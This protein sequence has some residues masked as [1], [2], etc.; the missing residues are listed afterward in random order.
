MRSPTLAVQGSPPSPSPL[1]QRKEGNGRAARRARSKKKRLLAEAAASTSNTASAHQVASD[2]ATAQSATVA[3]GDCLQSSLRNDLPTSIDRGDT[4]GTPIDGRKAHMRNIQ[5][6]EVTEDQTGDLNLGVAR[7]PT[8]RAPNTNADTD[9]SDSSDDDAAELAGGPELEELEAMSAWDTPYTAEPEPGSGAV[10][11]DDRRD[12][13]QATS[14]AEAGDDDGR[15]L[16]TVFTPTVIATKHNG[17]RNADPAHAGTPSQGKSALTPEGGSTTGADAHGSGDLHTVTVRLDFGSQFEALGER[18][19]PSASRVRVRLDASSTTHEVR[20]QVAADGKVTQR[21]PRIPNAQLLKATLTVNGKAWPDRT[22]IRAMMPD[23]PTVDQKGPAGAREGTPAEP[24]SR[25]S[26]LMQHQHAAHPAQDWPTCPVADQHREIA[27]GD[28]PFAPPTQRAAKAAASKAAWCMEEPADTAQWL[29]FA[30]ENATIKSHS[31]SLPEVPNGTW[32]TKPGEPTSIYAPMRWAEH[33]WDAQRGAWPRSYAE[34]AKPAMHTTAKGGTTRHLEACHAIFEDTGGPWITQWMRRQPQAAF[35]DKA[36]DRFVV[37][38]PQT[39]W[40]ESDKAARMLQKD[41]EGHLRVCQDS[42]SVDGSYRPRSAMLIIP[43]EC[44][45]GRGLITWDKRPFLI[46]RAAGLPTHDILIRPLETKRA[47]Q[48]NWNEARFR[49]R[50]AAA[51][52]RDEFAMDMATSTGVW[53]HTKARNDTMI[54]PCYRSATENAEAARELMAAEERQGFITAGFDGLPL[55]PM[56]VQPYSAQVDE[57]KPEK[58][59]RFCGDCTAFRGLEKDDGSE[60]VANSTNAGIQWRDTEYLSMMELTSA[61]VIARD[62][63]I[64]QS[65]PHPVWVFGADYKGYYR[66]IRMAYAE[67]NQQGLCL[68]STGIRIDLSA[69]FGNAAMPTQCCRISDILTQLHH[70]EVVRMFEL[71]LEAE[72]ESG[73]SYWSTI[74]TWARARFQLLCTAHAGTTD[75]PGAAANPDWRER[76]SRPEVI[77]SFFDDVMG[78]AFR[79]EISTHVADPKDPE[80]RDRHSEDGMHGLVVRAILH[81]SDDVGVTLA[82]HKLTCGTDDGR[83]GVLDMDKWLQDKA[84][85]VPP[86]ERRI[87]W[88]LGKGSMVML[89]KEIRLPKPARLADTDARIAG[90]VKD[91]NSLKAEMQVKANRPAV[92]IAPLRS[93]VQRGFYSVTTAPYAR[94]CLNVP[95]RSL[96]LCEAVFPQ[97]E[98]EHR[99][100][101]SSLKRRRKGRRPWFSWCFFDKKCQDHMQAFIDAIVAGAG[102]ALVPME[103]TPGVHGRAVV[104]IMEDASGKKCA[105]WSTAAQPRLG[106]A[107]AGGGGAFYYRVGNPQMKWSFSEHTLLEEENHS[108]TQEANNANANALRAIEWAGTTDLDIIEC[109]DNESWTMVARSGKCDAEAVS[110]PA[111]KRMDIWAG[112]P[113]V[114]IFTLFNRRTAGTC[115]DGFSNGEI[116]YEPDQT[117][118]CCRQEADS[119]RWTGIEWAIEEVSARTGTPKMDLVRDRL[120]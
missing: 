74:D 119:D 49:A 112:N 63:G 55:E 89:G 27:G 118:S 25:I 82:G 56:R 65:G 57:R 43:Q 17:T 71:K 8:H 1:E 13:V 72:Q 108:T 32:S 37:W 103:T 21:R 6:T 99:A 28:Y 2:T 88:F 94:P 53:T 52:V 36:G 11:T 38:S 73:G 24:W 46:A 33:E 77:Q 54:H 12:H 96:K 34:Q 92:P 85:G 91:W 105:D 98:K 5:P 80:Q 93:L 9:S 7:V 31:V 107:H 70:D 66:Q 78:A 16:R 114:R 58:A 18:T 14:E 35:T 64:L 44:Y 15:L 26:I 69:T 101:K 102:V 45:L 113:G 40:Q 84:A 83:T 41:W 3:V 86:Q 90:I 76:Q 61:R 51:G 67:L 110:V 50:C 20:N 30:V 120:R 10:A 117:R 115:Q 109:I 19:R 116:P 87:W 100:Q 79:G 75:S 81:V 47:V 60:P 48:S 62:V 22:P 23:A 104:W 42:K 111:Q 39:L 4:R 59:P 95:M 97:F 29:P 106:P 68:D